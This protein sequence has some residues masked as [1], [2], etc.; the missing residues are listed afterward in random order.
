MTGK[1]LVSGMRTTGSLHLGHLEG[2][3]KNWVALQDQYECFFFAAVWHAFTDRLKIEN[4]PGVIKEMIVDWLSVGIDPEKSVIF[5]QSEMHEHA[6]LCTILSNMTPLGWLERCPTFKDEVRDD[7]ARSGVA[8][9]KLMYPV[10]QTADIAAYKG[11]IVPVGKDQLPHLELSR[12]ILRRFNGQY[13][14]ILPEPEARLSS[15]PM[16][17]GIDKRKMSKSYDNGIYLR[18]TSD[19]L[20]QKV[21]MMITDPQRVRR[22]DPGDPEVCA[23]FAYHRIYTPDRLEEIATGCRNAS[24]GCRDCKAILF[25]RLDSML[26]PIRQKRAEIENKCGFVEDVLAAGEKRAHQVAGET[27]AEI[28][29][30]MG[31]SF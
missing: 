30:A 31:F 14:E 5:R 22:N 6:E 10:L 18:E 27:M 7:E 21:Q 29:A 26:E 2:T 15:V 25:E 19:S 28:R 13:G 12:E 4:L 24:I 8:L 3:L 9:G 20:K 11:E 23:V 17:L 16:L 1:R